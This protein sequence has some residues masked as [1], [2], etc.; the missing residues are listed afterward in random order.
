M[1]M[2]VRFGWIML[3]L[4]L[5]F[6]HIA[7]ELWVPSCVPSWYFLPLASLVA[8]VLFALEVWAGDSWIVVGP[9]VAVACMALLASVAGVLQEFTLAYTLTPLILA[10]LEL[11]VAPAWILYNPSTSQ[12]V[13]TRSLSY[14]SIRA[15]GTALFR[16]TLHDSSRVCTLSRLLPFA[17]ATCET[18]AM[19]FYRPSDSYTFSIY[20]YHFALY[21][22]LKTC[23]FLYVPVLEDLVRLIPHIAR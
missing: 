19:L 18:T 22:T 20:S 23:V 11:L 1:Q 13:A 8:I 4:S 17:A 12:F 10:P 14:A 9:S 5:A 6:A 7:H 21:T 16:A 3:A 15:F 2:V